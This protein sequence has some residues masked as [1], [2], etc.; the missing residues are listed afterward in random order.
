[1]AANDIA[2]TVL[3]AAMVT[4]SVLRKLNVLRRSMGI[5]ENTGE[6]T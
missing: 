1:M 5:Y 6:A 3:A 2:I 4:K